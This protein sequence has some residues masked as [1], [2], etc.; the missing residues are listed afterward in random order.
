M[1]KIN[2]KYIKLIVQQA[3]REDLNP[4]GDITSRN[5]NNKKITAKI[6][7]GQN[8]IIG[9]LNFAKE[10][11]KVSD[12]KTIFK[13]KIIDGKKVKKGKVL[14]SLKGNAKSIL[15]AERVA[16]NF[17]GLISGVATITNKFV[18]KV[19]GKSCKICCTR[20]T[21]PNLRLIQKY[22]VSLGGGTNHRF[23]LSDEILIKDNHIAI[24]KNI[25][26]LV[27]RSIKNRNGKKITVEVDN[28]NQLKK[29]IGL[30]FNRVLFDNMN[31]KNLRKAV[32][33]SKKYY[34]T[35]ASGGV[36]LKNIKK[37]SSTGVNRISIGQITHSAPSV[38][39]KLDFIS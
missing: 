15:K 24:N 21:L 10:T 17:I 38:D 5:I 37:I 11:F 28:I 26:N 25:K 4:S 14:A 36:T 13:T 16:L 18:K 6:I 29:I 39:C 2:N 12:K 22:G 1:Q 19:N 33:I 20:K 27:Q 23:N 7:A 30:K 9:G 31:I 34:E 8:C 35:E 3:L 32:K